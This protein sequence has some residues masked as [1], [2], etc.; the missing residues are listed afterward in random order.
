MKLIREKKHRLPIQFYQGERA[1]FI[2]ANIKDRKNAFENEFI[3]RKIEKIFL[4][5][6][7]VQ[8]CDL[9]VYLFMPDHIHFIIVGNDSNADIWKCLKMFKQKS[10]Y[11]LNQNTQF[12]WQKDYYDQILRSNKNL[13][14]TMKYIL[15]NPGRRGICEDWRDFTYK[16]STVYNLNEWDALF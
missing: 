9:F 14:M 6:I 5:T 16:G 2:T 1:V 3:L 7:E 15:E 8:N 13:N 11:W 4:E 10:G 12:Q